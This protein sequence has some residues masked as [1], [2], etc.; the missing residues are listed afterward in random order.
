MKGVRHVQ[1]EEVVV[2]V[3]MV[4]KKRFFPKVRH[5]ALQDPDGVV[6]AVQALVRR[7]RSTEAASATHAGVQFRNPLNR[8]HRSAHIDR[9]GSVRFASRP[10]C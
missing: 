9:A 10:Y 1:G 2:V 5:R 6:G 4:V 8:I 3:A 7:E